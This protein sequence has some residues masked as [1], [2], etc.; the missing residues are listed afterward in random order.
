MR[1][2]K[3]VLCI[4]DDP[5]P[6]NFRCS[7]LS[8]IGYN[9]LSAGSGHEGIRVFSKDH[10]DAVVVDLDHDN[11]EAA[12]VT[13]ELKRLRSS[14][15]IAV[16]VDDPSSIAPDARPSAEAIISKAEESRLLPGVLSTLLSVH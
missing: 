15:P 16:L 5:V 11:A 14:T 10:V 4:G 3:S 9:V 7:L 1:Q 12:L 8:K 13:G 2:R 6:L